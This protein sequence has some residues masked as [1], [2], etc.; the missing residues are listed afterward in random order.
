VT[1]ARDPAQDVELVYVAADCVLAAFKSINR[2]QFGK[3]SAL[4]A[5]LDGKVY[6][7][8]LDDLSKKLKALADEWQG[9]LDAACTHLEGA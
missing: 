2:I 3:R 5:L 6:P 9:E 8:D 1:L 4:D 7:G